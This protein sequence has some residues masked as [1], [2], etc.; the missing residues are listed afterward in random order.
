MLAVRLVE[1]VSDQELRSCLPLTLTEEVKIRN[2]I[3]FLKIMVK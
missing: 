1:Q 2:V 3:L